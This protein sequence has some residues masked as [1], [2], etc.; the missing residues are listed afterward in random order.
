MKTHIMTNLESTKNGSKNRRSLKNGEYPLM[1]KEL[2]HWFI[3]QRKKHIPVNGTALKTKAIEIQN[4]LYSG[5]FHASD[6]WLSR[7]KKRY[8]IR[9]LKESGEKLSSRADLVE[10][11]K[12][13]L[14]N[15]IIENNL[16]L[17]AI[18][19]ANETGMYWK[20]LPDKT[21]VH[22]GEVTAPEVELFL[23]SKSLPIKALLILDNAP[24]HP[25]KD[26]LVKSTKDGKI[27]T[28]FMP[29]NVTPLI[30]PMDQNAIRL[31]KLQYRNSLLSKIISL[32]AEDIVLFLKNINLYEAT[33]MISLAWKNLKADTLANCWHKLLKSNNGDFD[34]EDDIPLAQLFH[35]EEIVN[36]RRS[37]RLLSTVFPEITF[38]TDDINY[39]NRDDDQDNDEED[40]D[41]N[42][43]PE[44]IVNITQETKIRNADAINSF[45]TCILWSQQNNIDCTKSLV[46]RELQEEAVQKSLQLGQ[47]QTSIN[48]F[49]QS[50]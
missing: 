16:T 28:I 10:P 18:F 41:E 7:Y 50:S 14:Q 35:I 31:V 8:G 43:D 29:P 5:G 34:E 15:I 49:F 42:V 32:G 6:G 20:M 21:F 2:Y 27:W 13:D 4:R 17:D 19:N 46:L 3:E 22:A 45:E 37:N 1:E 9:L 40:D 30:Q 12:K 26:Q 25:P 39:W 11:F 44:E 24:S 38:T 36:I 33:S 48:D 47:K 23:E